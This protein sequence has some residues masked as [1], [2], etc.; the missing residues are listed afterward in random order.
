[1]NLT[2]SKSCQESLR[3]IFFTCLAFIY[4]LHSFPL[5]VAAPVDQM[6]AYAT[7]QSAMSSN[8]LRSVVQQ[9]V[10]SSVEILGTNTTLTNSTT[11]QLV[12]NIVNKLLEAGIQTTP[13][14]KPKTLKELKQ[15]FLNSVLNS[16]GFGSQS[17]DG[18]LGLEKLTG[19][20]DVY[21]ITTSSSCPTSHNIHIDP[22]CYGNGNHSHCSMDTEL[23]PIVDDLDQLENYF[24]QYMLQ[25]VCRG[26]NITDAHCLQERNSCYVHEK[27]SPPFR[28]LRRITGE[29]DENGYEKW[30]LDEVE[31]A[32]VVACSCRQRSE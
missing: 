18:C 19:L 14:C 15:Q 28:P 2:L 16:P 20:K 13:Q 17:Q 26:C 12:S 31:L 5:S 29:C 10:S 22:V 27:Q 11:C 9:A 21:Y 4:Q 8:Q 24:P 23:Q 3:I 6:A 7:R 1:M 25:I 32:A 30:I